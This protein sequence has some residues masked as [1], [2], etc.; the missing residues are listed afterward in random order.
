MCRHIY[1]WNIVNCDVKQ[2]I[3]LNSIY[4]D[5]ASMQTL[6]ICNPKAPYP[7]I[8]MDNFIF[9]S[10]HYVKLY[11]WIFNTFQMPLVRRS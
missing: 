11:G 7:D 10:D 6:K 8:N 4:D 2:P 1:D 3:Q 5:V 9:L